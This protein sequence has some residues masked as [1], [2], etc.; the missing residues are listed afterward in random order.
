MVVSTSATDCLERLVSEMTY[1]VSGGTRNPTHSLTP[2]RGFQKL[3]QEQDR[4]CKTDAT[5]RIT[6]S[7]F[8]GGNNFK[9]T[10]AQ[11]FDA[12]ILLSLEKI[13][14]GTVATKNGRVHYTVMPFLNL[15]S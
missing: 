14:A 8:V 6:T 3:E 5:E 1:Y 13:L 7:R 2:G 9:F 11:V 10:F 15:G 12:H 4:H